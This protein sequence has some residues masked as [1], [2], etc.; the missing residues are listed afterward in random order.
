MTKSW[1]YKEVIKSMQSISR[2]T[3]RKGMLKVSGS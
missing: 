2:K 3:H 1:S